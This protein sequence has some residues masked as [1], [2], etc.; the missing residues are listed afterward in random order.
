MN[1]FKNSIIPRLLGLVPVDSD[2][3]FTEIHLPRNGSG[4]LVFGDGTDD[5]IT[6]CLDALLGQGDASQLRLY[7]PLGQNLATRAVADSR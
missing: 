5:P 2:G 4:G 7:S 1:Q 6:A 3:L